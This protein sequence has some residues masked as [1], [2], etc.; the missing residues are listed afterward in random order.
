MIKSVSLKYI[1]RTQTSFVLT[2]EFTSPTSFQ[3]R[4]AIA[5]MDVAKNTS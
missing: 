2:R 1:I 5:N 3:N 4:V